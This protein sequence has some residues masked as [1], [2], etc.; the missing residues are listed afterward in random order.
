MGE[1]KAGDGIPTPQ[2]VEALEG[3]LSVL[4]LFAPQPDLEHLL[5]VATQVEIESDQDSQDELESFFPLSQDNEHIVLDA[6][7][8]TVDADISD[9]KVKECEDA[10]LSTY[11]DWHTAK[12]DFGEYVSEVRQEIERKRR[13][14][15][16]R[17]REEKAK[18]LAEKET[19]KRK[20]NTASKKSD[21]HKRTKRTKT[22]R[23]NL[24]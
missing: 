5:S 21:K 2:S 4:K 1:Q 15:K 19:K 18:A 17:A 24:F 10:E 20:T 7:N 9:Q 16:R 23:K 13:E 11:N 3:L 8:M 12:S 14:E 6:L 22:H